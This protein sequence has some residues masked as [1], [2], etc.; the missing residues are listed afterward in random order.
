MGC[1]FNS[2]APLDVL[3]TPT[4]QDRTEPQNPALVKHTIDLRETSM[5]A[6][7]D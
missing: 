1:R 7:S 3:D 4:R 6:I 2:A 5:I